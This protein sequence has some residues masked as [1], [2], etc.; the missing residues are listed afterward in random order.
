ML[1][2]I[3][4]N[5]S[6]Q[7]MIFSTEMAIEGNEVKVIDEEIIYTLG[8]YKTLLF[9]WITKSELRRTIEWYGW[10]I[11]IFPWCELAQFMYQRLGFRREMQEDTC[12]MDVL[13]T[14]FQCTQLKHFSCLKIKFVLTRNL[15]MLPYHTVFKRYKL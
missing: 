6:T 9:S 1:I 4:F 5:L 3:Q 11:W 14:H 7:E 12:R 8:W 10:C 15:T 2:I 13:Y